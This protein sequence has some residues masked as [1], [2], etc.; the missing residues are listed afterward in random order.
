VVKADIHFVDIDMSAFIPPR[1][2]GVFFP[3]VDK[4]LLKSLRLGGDSLLHVDVYCKV[5]LKKFKLL[6][7]PGHHMIRKVL[8]PATWTQVFLG[9]PV[10]I[11]EC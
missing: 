6:D 9:F 5:L 10:S 3:G 4:I 2:E 8:R 11:N 7:I 1:N